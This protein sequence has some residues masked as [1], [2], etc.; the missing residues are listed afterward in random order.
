MRE[1]IFRGKREKDGVWVYGSYQA[2]VMS[3]GRHTIIY[4]DYEGFY[5]E[6]EIIPQSVGQYTGLKDKRG[7]RIYEGD[8]L[9]FDTSYAGKL[10]CTV[11]YDA[12]KLDQASFLLDTNGMTNTLNDASKI[13]EV[14]G[15]IHE[16]T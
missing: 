1:I 2:D 7:K 10:R 8:V 5:C 6:D 4:S 15:N 11:Y 14:I 9:E 16:N 12:D 13:Y 3:F